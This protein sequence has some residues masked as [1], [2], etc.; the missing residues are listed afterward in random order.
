[1][2]LIIDGYNLLHVTGVFGGKFADGTLESA[3]VALLDMLADSLE[4]RD[5]AQATVVFD[6]ADAPPGLPRS[7]KHRGI[8][9]YFA[10]DHADADSMIEELIEKENAPQRLSVV[11]SD[12]RLHRAARRRRATAVDSDV[13][14]ADLM[15]RRGERGTTTDASAKPQGKPSDAEV[16]FWLKEFGTEDKE[17]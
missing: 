16:Q 5:R 7:A 15:R 9:V 1:M 6:A 13:W 3:R 4:P 12:H 14:Y 11:S 8:R 2:S 17:A 10:A